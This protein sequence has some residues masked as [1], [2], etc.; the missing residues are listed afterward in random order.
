MIN[1]DPDK[2]GQLPRRMWDVDGVLVGYHRSKDC[3]QNVHRQMCMIG[4]I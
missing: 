4:K 3:K 1:G 2:Q